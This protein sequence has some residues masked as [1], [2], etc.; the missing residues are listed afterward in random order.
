MNS[1]FQ[2]AFV[3][4]LVLVFDESKIQA[5]FKTS[6]YEFGI[7]AGTMVYQ[8]DLAPHRAGDYTALKPFVGLSVSRLL[9]QYLAVSASLNFGKLTTDE[10]R[11]S[12]PA[13]RQDR[14]FS[15]KTNVTELTTM[16]TWK[17][18][19]STAYY[20]PRFT[21]YVFAGAGL[22]FLHTQKDWSKLNTT[23]YDAESQVQIG[24]ASDIVQPA[25]RVIP[26]VP[27]GLGARYQFTRQMSFNAGINYRF[28]VS[29]Y[30][31]G[32]KYSGNADKNDSYFG[33]SLGLQYSFGRYKCPPVK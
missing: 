4:C 6:R 20:Q 11:N 33:I 8:G 32:F 27:T 9:G 16:L 17:L 15:F 3:T 7:N 18:I 28:T 5:Q 30:I 31:D 14:A 19:K 25:H 13:W 22:A 26:V 2:L 10:S 24:L 21:P 1:V 29:D 23:A 12:T